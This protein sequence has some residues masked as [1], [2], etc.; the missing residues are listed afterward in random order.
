MLT[1]LAS[2][3]L[4]A[5]IPDAIVVD[6]CFRSTD[7]VADYDPDGPI[8]HDSV[9]IERSHELGLTAGERIRIRRFCKDY[10]TSVRYI[11]M[12]ARVHPELRGSK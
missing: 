3:A 5:G 2:A 8:Y 9:M 4:L 6:V 10:V 1:L 7:A 12:Q 11:V